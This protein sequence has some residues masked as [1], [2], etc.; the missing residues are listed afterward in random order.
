MKIN[1]NIFLLV[2]ILFICVACKKIKYYPDKPYGDV[3]TKVL[4]HRGGGNSSYQ[5]NTLEAA[6][7]GLSTLD[8]IEVD[9]Q[10]S[11]NRT[12]WMF[13]SAELPDCGGVSYNCFPE[14]YNSQ[15]IELDSCLGN[16]FV[17]S[18]LEE[19]FALMSS[20]YT[21]KFISL[22]VKAWAPCEVTSLGIT[23][24]MNVIADEIVYL[25][26]KYNLNGHVM[27]ESETTSF[28]SYLKRKSVGVE[29]Y[30][31]TLGDFERG[32][33]IALKGGFTGLSFKYKF[34]EEITEDH[35]YLI[36][37]KGLKIQLW[38]VNEPDEI[39]EAIFINPDYIQTDNLAYFQSN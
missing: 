36:R 16:T 9:I 27:V 2:L 38:T 7:Y 37:K 26:D 35:I 18:R 17:L 6:S 28:L 25:T 22:D 14:T 23:G 1:C 34:D 24:I 5:E 4:A 21:D 11:K 39:E 29:T 19:V 3:E 10:I 30:L 32:M 31:S 15:I 12:I 13:H 33:Q 20:L 8:G